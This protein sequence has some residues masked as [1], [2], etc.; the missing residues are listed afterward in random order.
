MPHGVLFRGAA[1]G[2]IRRFIIEQKNYLD[3][4][5]GLPANLFYGTSIP[6]CILVFKKCRTP[7]ESVLFIDASRE[8]TKGKN[9]NYL[10]AKNIDK[11]IETYAARAEIDKYSHNASLAEIAE[12]DFNLNIPRHVD[13]FEPEP[14]IDLTAVTAEI[15]Q[16][17][18]K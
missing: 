18:Q 13:T 5:I 9:Q 16:I 10:S 4:I 3:T 17:D 1:E 7:E 2:V 11:I 15:K 6:A 12:N 8:F 14:E